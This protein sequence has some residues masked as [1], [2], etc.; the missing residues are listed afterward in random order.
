MSDLDTMLQ[1]FAS[2]I[3]EELP[4][5]DVERVLSVAA[6]P[7][8]MPRRW[9][10]PVLVAAAS[11]M[12]VLLA[13]GLPFLFLSGDESTVVDEPSTTVASCSFLPS[14]VKTAPLPALNRGES[15]IVTTTIRRIGG[16]YSKNLAVQG[17]MFGPIASCPT[18]S[19]AS[20]FLTGMTLSR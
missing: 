11:A 8:A 17:S 4:P 14:W 9:L 1:D 7:P 16:F 6:M 12:L 15:S 5:P 3:E 10:R 13:V 19:I 20:L 2:F 18:T